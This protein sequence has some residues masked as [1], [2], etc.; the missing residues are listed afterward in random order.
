MRQLRSTI[1]CLAL[2]VLLAGC[3][4]VQRQQLHPPAWIYGEWGIESGSGQ[5]YIK[6][7]YTFSP[8]TVVSNMVLNGQHSSM[9]YAE[10]YGAAGVPVTETITD[11]LYSFA[12][13]TQTGFSTQK[14]AKVDANT[15]LWTATANGMSS[16]FTLHRL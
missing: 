8:T 11:S 15:I 2:L 13:P 5:S 3:A 14:F 12:T 6:V 1:A 9:D 10:L 4:Q 7:S 16:G